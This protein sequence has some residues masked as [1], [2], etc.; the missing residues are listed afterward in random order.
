MAIAHSLPKVLLHDHLDGSLRISTLLDLCRSQGLVAPASDEQGLAHWFEANAMAGSLERYLQ[1]FALTVRAM[2]SPAALERVAFEAAEDAQAE[3]C[4]LAEFRIAPTL[5]EPL[6]LRAEAAVEALLQGLG[7][8]TLPCG[9][10]ICGMRQHEAEQVARSAELA[11]RY[12]GAVVGFDLAGPEAGFPAS[13][14]AATLARLRDEGMPL[15]L[16]AGEADVAE[17][18]EEAIALGARRIGHGVRL[19]DWLG[20]EHVQRVRAVAE[21]S[22]HLEMCPSSNLHTGAVSRLQDHPIARLHR[23]GVA[24]SFHTDNRLISCTSQSREAALLVDMLGLSWHDLRDM[25]MAAARA[26]FL[27]QAQKDEALALIAAWTGP[28]P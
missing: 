1:G 27:P 9:L 15:T 3:G 5:F 6:G 7:R 23:A 17:R 13:R 12:R 20:T 22:V 10:I 25:S 21:A 19:A 28:A 16:H 2:A 8:S 11:L 14:H 4:V 26:S 18:V 24:V